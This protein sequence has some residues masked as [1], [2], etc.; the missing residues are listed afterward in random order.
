MLALVITVNLELPE[1]PA[2]EV[3]SR[4]QVMLAGQLKE[5]S[6]VLLKPFNDV[7]VIVAL[8]VSPGLSVRDDGLAEIAKSAV[9]GAPQPLNV[10][11]PTR[12]YQP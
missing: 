3:G 10:N 11:D 6:T 4:P 8:P 9:A 7:T 2:T 5:R 12:V 1:P